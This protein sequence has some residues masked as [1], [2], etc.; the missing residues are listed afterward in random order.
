MS[1]RNLSACQL[2]DQDTPLSAEEL[3][4]A[5]DARIEWVTELLECGI[6]RGLDGSVH[7]ARLTQLRFDSAELTR[8]LDARRL[9]RD[10]DIN[11]DA[12]ALIL[13]LQT[14]LRR[15]RALLLANGLHAG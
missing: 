5:C 10:Y 3:A 14:E 2:I 9:Q 4:R 6:V 11:L 8:A 15:L 12:T 7:G 1:T 13:D